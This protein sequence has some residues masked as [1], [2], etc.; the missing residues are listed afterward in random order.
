MAYQQHHAWYVFPVW[1]HITSANA[2]IIKMLE[3]NPAL[4]VT[5]VTHSLVDTRRFP[6]FPK[7]RFRLLTFGDHNISKNVGKNTIAE[8]IAQLSKCWIETLQE[9]CDDTQAWPKPTALMLDQ[10]GSLHTLP[11][12]RNIVGPDCKAYMYW[13]GSAARLYSFLA[14]SGKGGFSDWEEIV[15]KYVS[16]ET[17]RKG[18]DRSEIIDK[19]CIAKNGFDEF[20]GTIISIPGIQDMYDYEREFGEVPLQAGVSSMLRETV[21]LAKA[22]DG[23]VCAS[24]MALEGETIAACQTYTTVHPVGVQVAPR[25]WYKNGLVVK[26]ESLLAF[27]DSH[28]KEEVVLISFGSLVFPTNKANFQALVSALI[29]FKYPFVLVLGGMFAGKAIDP[30][31]ISRINDSGVGHVCDRWVDQQALLQHPSI[32]WL[33]AHGGFNS[34]VESLVQGIPLIGWPLAP[35][36]NAINTA[37]V[38]TG[39]EPVAFEVMQVR[40]GSARGKPRRDGSDIVGTPESVEQEFRDILRKMRGK[41]GSDRRAN[42]QALAEDLRIEKDTVAKEIVSKLAIT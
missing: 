22:T 38:S 29:E 34:T 10:N 14:P 5:Y 25:G 16:D 2:L 31:E 9:A 32:G 15:H 11:Q 36:D 3:E 19:V 24:S 23:V 42:A 27:L 41:E 35:G 17:L 1:G 21:S 33:F 28:G 20:N 18:R 6:E 7:D 40:T 30:S 8:G 37:V 13:A 12:V 26:D 4:V 39:K